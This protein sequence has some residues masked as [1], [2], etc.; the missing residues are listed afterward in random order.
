[1][2]TSSERSIAIKI[3][4]LSKH[5]ALLG[6]STKSESVTALDNINIDVYQGEVIGIAGPNGSGKSTLLKILSEVT[7]PDSG[8]VEIQGEIAS[9]LE[10]GIGFNPDLSGRKNIY[11]NAR[12]HGL[13]K[14]EVDDKLNKII[15]LFGFPKFL[16]TPVKQYSS[17]MFMRLAF[18]VVVNIDADIYLFDEVLSVGDSTFRNKI[19]NLIR[20][21]RNNGKTIL[22]VTHTPGYI[23][24]ICNKMLLLNEGKIE[25]Y[26]ITNI[27]LMQY[28]KALLNNS[29]NENQKINVICRNEKELLNIKQTLDNVNSE[30]QFD[31][32]NASVS[33]LENTSDSIIYGDKEINFEFECY[34]QTK[35]RL[36]IAFAIINKEDYVISTHTFDTPP[37][38]K[39][40]IIAKMTF[41]PK[42]FNEA[43]CIIDVFVFFDGLLSV[44]YQ[45]IF[46][47]NIKSKHNHT[48]SL[49]K[50]YLS[51]VNLPVDKNTISVV[52]TF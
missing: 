14:K 4:N 35:E 41:P 33:N 52:N 25:I 42:T 45:H 12:L 24:E 9:I 27:V 17:G 28:R 16:D 40:K 11:L 8:F 19:I 2:P 43:E 22:I 37:V 23:G 6:K 31:I 48:F 13:Q 3:R 5:Y 32:I 38:G 47:F 10:V 1:M 36:Q 51:L 50:Y 44:L 39:N 30:N 21:L 18:A 29:L 34:Y 46:I 7:A 15:D 26:D 49:E 20:I